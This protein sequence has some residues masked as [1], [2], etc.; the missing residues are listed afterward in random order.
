MKNKPTNFN[1]T[2]EIPYHVG[3]EIPVIPY[4]RPGSPELAKAVVE[5]MLE[6]LS[7]I[8]I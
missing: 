3:S 8:H 7:L 5:A 1:V 6:H 2:A 4:Y